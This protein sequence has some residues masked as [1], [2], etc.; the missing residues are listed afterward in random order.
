MDMPDFNRTSIPGIAHHEMPAT[1]RDFLA[2]SGAGFGA[3]AMAYML[4]GQPLPAR[5]SADDILSRVGGKPKLMAG[6]SPLAA[7][8][9]HYF[10][11][12][13]NVIFVFMEGGPSHIDLFDPKPKLVELAGKP[14]PASFKPVITAMGEY[15]AP[16]LA[17]KRQWKQ[18]GQSGLGGGP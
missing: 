10:G 16:L 2:R 8:P 15:N 1:R 4:A 17:S 12:A 6:L 3:L 9:P 13:K 5:G 7:R 11:K 18:C 14:L